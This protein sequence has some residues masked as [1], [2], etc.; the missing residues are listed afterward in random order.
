MS[1]DR[2]RVL[3]ID[4][5]VQNLNL[6]KACFRHDF[7]IFLAKSAQEG[8]RHLEQHDIQVIVSDQKMPGVTGVQFFESILEKY[9]DPV[10]ILLTAYTDVEAL[11]DAINKGQIFRY[12]RKPWEEEDLRMTVRSAYQIYSANRQLLE[13][14]L[15]LQ[16]KNDELNRFVYS[17]SHDLKAPLGS[18]QG[19]LDL[20]K[21]EG[22]AGNASEYLSLIEKSV[23]QLEVFIHNIIQYYKNTQLKEQLSEIDFTKVI[24]EIL[25]SYQYYQFTPHIDFRV[26]IA[27]PDQFIGDMFRIRTIL[28]NLL[29][30]AIKY[31]RKEEPNKYVLIDVNTAT[32]QVTIRVEDN[33]IGI[34]GEHLGQ[35]YNMFFRATTEN[36]GSGMG[37]YILNEALAKIGGKIHVTS[38]LGAGTTFEVIL[39]NRIQQWYE[40]NKMTAVDDSVRQ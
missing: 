17:A 38:A 4:D 8:L 29:S 10:R 20:S 9:P 39:P 3:Y 35:I 26:R 15:E 18:I 11:I 2:I 23:K 37:L 24:N 1:Q 22:E 28:N 32:E 30:N 36:S 21:M 6:F 14:N 25:E 31:Q 19:I 27:Q 12:L 40:L 34:P 7:E 13:K 16:K 5:E 33:G